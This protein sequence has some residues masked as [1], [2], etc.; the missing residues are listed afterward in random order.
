MGIPRLAS[1]ARFCLELSVRRR[2]VMEPAR[3]LTLCH[4]ATYLVTR[5]C[6]PVLTTRLTTTSIAQ[7]SRP[8]AKYVR[9]T[10]GKMRQEQPL[11]RRSARTWATAG[12]WTMVC[13]LTRK[14]D[15]VHLTVVVIVALKT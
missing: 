5:R 3:R 10:F 2:G 13:T 7:R 9:A 11:A 1:N 14:G 15:L 12:Q 8:G 6:W 4:M